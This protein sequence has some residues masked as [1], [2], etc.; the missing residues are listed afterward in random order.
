VEVKESKTVKNKRS[1]EE[2]AR[3]VEEILHAKTQRLVYSG[4]EEMGRKGEGKEGL[5]KRK[6]VRRRRGEGRSRTEP[7]AAMALKKIYKIT[8]VQ[9]QRS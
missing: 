1:N 5:G 2:R 3:C 6:D 7:T 8:Y 9:V 4:T